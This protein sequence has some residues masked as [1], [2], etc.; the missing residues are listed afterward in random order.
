[1]SAVYDAPMAITEPD[2]ALLKRA[3]ALA[4]KAHFDVEPNPPVGCV[5]VR[6]ADGAVGEGWT[7][8]WGGPHAEVVALRAAGERAAGATAYVSLAPCG[9]A[10][11]TPPC[12]EAL[13]EAGVRRVVVG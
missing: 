1:M 9:H 8:P 13:V 11:K 6:G 10:G 7:A 2:A 4:R 3:L 5:L 12:A